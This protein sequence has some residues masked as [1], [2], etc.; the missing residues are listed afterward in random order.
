MNKG[1]VVIH[2]DI[3]DQAL[4]TRILADYEINTIFHLAAQTL[5]GQASRWPTDTFESNIKGT[6]TVLEAA[7]LLNIQ[8]VL[9][10]SSDKAYG[11]LHGNS[12][13]EQHPLAGKY[14]YDVS[15]SCSDL[16]AQSYAHSFGLNVTITRCGNSFGPGDLNRSRLFP[17]TILSLMN[18]ER[19]VVRSDGKFIRDYIYVSDGAA[20]YRLL[21]K[22][23]ISQN[24]AGQ[25]FNF[26]YGLRMTVLDVID[27]I[28]KQM[29]TD[30]APLILNEA[31][32]EIPVQCLDAKKAKEQLNWKPAFGFEAGVDKS[33]AWYKET[34]PK[35]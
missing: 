20:A 18:N 30:L 5:V 4:I 11:N 3:T 26:S 34:Q 7:R 25:A 21:A 22:A 27:Q 13:D 16:I 33:I 9:V 35:I 1:S 23:M 17:G 2:G 24:L 12:Y 15:K 8:R 6:W 31:R 10:A 19:P 29:G 14:P 28:Q 32:N